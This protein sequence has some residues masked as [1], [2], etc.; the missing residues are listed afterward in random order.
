MKFNNLVPWAGENDKNLMETPLASLEREMN[1]MFRHFSRNF[2]E[3]APFRTEMMERTALMPRV[4]VAETDEEVQVNAELPGME[5]KDIGVSFADNVLTIEGEKKHEKEEKHKNY[6]RMERSFGKFQRKIPLPAEI[7]PDK[8]DAVFKKGI[9]TVKLPKSEKA[10]K[11]VKKITV[12]V[13]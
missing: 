4:D 10:K 12:K 9:L 7:Q 2:F 13:N 6:Y 1:R 11:E 3:E 5:E 8:I